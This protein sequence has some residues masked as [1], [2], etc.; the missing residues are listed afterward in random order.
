MRLDKSALLLYAV[1]DRA[2]LGER[3]LAQQVEQ[4]LE[5]GVTMLQL[6]EKHLDRE[7]FRAE[8][9]ELKALCRAY[10]VPFLI[11]DDVEL[12][13]EVDADGVHVGQEDMEAGRARAL[14]GADKIVGVSAHTVAEALSAQ[15]AGADYLGLGA[16]FPTGTKTDVD[17]LSRQT[18]REICAAVDIPCVAIGG[19]GPDN[20]LELAGCGLA[21]V[22]VVSAI[23][24]QREIQSACRTLR[25]LSGEMVTA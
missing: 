1:T 14:L 9:L 11:N 16:V 23:F 4:A 19:I 12:A 25:R 13:L 3:T 15:A 20:L 5:G 8:A 17:V 24:A 2:W 18:L 7:A 21:G 22:S 10:R 6:R